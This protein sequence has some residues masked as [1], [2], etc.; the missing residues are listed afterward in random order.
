MSTLDDKLDQ[1]ESSTRGVI[2]TWLRESDDAG[3]FRVCPNAWAAA[4]GVPVHDAVDAML[5]ATQAG[6]VRIGWELSCPGCGLIIDSVERFGDLH[7]HFHCEICA[8]SQDIAL[9]D[10]IHVTFTVRPEVRR[11]RFHDPGSLSLRP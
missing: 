4:R 8:K 6:L 7:N 9:D 2:E 1:L 10:W 11:T 5:R 3:V